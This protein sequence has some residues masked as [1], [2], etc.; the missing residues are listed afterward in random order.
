MI[1]VG[2]SLYALVAIIVC[3]AAYQWVSVFSYPRELEFM[4]AIACFLGVALVL[5]CSGLIPV[6][7]YIA[8]ITHN[9]DGEL[10]YSADEIEGMQTV[11]RIVYYVLYS[12]ILFV[13]FVLLPMAYFYHEEED[14]G[15][16][17]RERLLASLKYTFLLLFILAIIMAIGIIVQIKQTPP[18]SDHSWMD[19]I[20]KSEKVGE[21]ALN[22]AIAAFAALGLTS[23]ISYTSYGFAALPIFLMKAPQTQQTMRN[24]RELLEVNKERQRAIKEKYQF[25]RGRSMTAADQKK[26]RQLQQEQKIMER[27]ATQQRSQ[28]SCATLLI[29]LRPFSVFLGFVWMMFNFL[30]II[31]LFLSSLDRS[32]NS[33]CG[34]ECGFIL[35]KPTYPNPIDTVLVFFSPY[36]PTDLVI[37]AIVVV[38]ILVCTIYGIYRLG[39]RFV[40]VQLYSLRFKRTVP[41][42]MIL[43]TV[44]LMLTVITTNFVATTLAPQYTAFGMQMYLDA[45]G[46]TQE[47]SV[48][49]PSG[50]CF[51]TE[52]YLLVSRISLKGPI[53]AVIFLAGNF[54]ISLWTVLTFLYKCC[55][56]AENSENGEDDD[57]T[58]VLDDDDEESQFLTPPSTRMQS[59]NAQSIREKYF[60]S[61]RL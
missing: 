13:A 25:T 2:W 44:I 29:C 39:V 33:L 37:I 32:A 14:I 16:T 40:C 54:A 48:D 4:T 9:S 57:D 49:T 38:D 15:V 50:K 60:G 10:Q 42:S 5:L 7:I 26:L 20:F 43:S 36:F 41:Q 18:T 11:I 6:D 51:M 12:C 31:T 19:D 55:Q 17:S 46:V 45:D 30:L 28:S 24:V 61:G 34:F 23:F 58:D 47:C 53:F 35:D 59:T 56:T 21:G 22:F 3:F 52:M 8:S 1:A 27:Q